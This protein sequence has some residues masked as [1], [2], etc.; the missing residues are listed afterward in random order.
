MQDF[1]ETS[2]Q[3]VDQVFELLL[4]S[5]ALGKLKPNERIRQTELADRFGV[6]RQP[7][8]H[9][10]QVLKHQ[11]LVRDAGKQGVEVAP[12]DPDYVVH[13]YR[14]RS[15]LEATAAS[16]A[17]ERVRSG[18]A[19]PRQLEEL[20]KALADGQAAC[21]ERTPLPTLVRADFRFHTALYRLSANPAIEQMMAS[22]WP[23]LMRS[24]MA[25]LDDPGVPTRAWEEHSLIATAVLGG[26]ADDSR[27][28]S[29]KH[30]HRA[31]ADL[32]RRLNA[33]RIFAVSGDMRGGRG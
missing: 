7:V 17:A 32:S 28:I 15:A 10:L 33:L 21:D 1:V 13:L 6:S 4:D 12:I 26:R 24:M 5:I 27:D 20:A 18:E 25:V 23:H 30:L 9:A 19:A 11:G 14:A 29:T 16:L 8:S 3:Y 22:Q 2:P 31:C